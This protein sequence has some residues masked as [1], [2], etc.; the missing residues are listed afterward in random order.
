MP[1]SY[2]VNS[3]IRGDLM[4]RSEYSAVA[5]CAVNNFTELINGIAQTKT[6]WL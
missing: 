2:A 3:A 4:W 1:F 5:F 6:L